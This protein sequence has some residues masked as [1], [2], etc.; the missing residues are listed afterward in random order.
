MSAQSIKIAS[1]NIEDA[2]S[3]ETR[4]D[5]VVKHIIALDADIVML[6]EAF[7]KD[8]HHDNDTIYSAEA[9]LEDA[10]YNVDVTPYFDADERKDTHWFAALTRGSI[11][12]N[13]VRLRLDSRDTLSARLAELPLTITGVH[14]DDRT[15]V[16]RHRQAISLAEQHAS[17]QPN[18]LMGDFNAMHRRDRRARVLHAAGLVANHLPVVDPGEEAP[19][20]PRL[21]RIGSLSSRLVAMAD[22]GTMASLENIYGYKDIDPG[23]HATRGPVQIDHILT[24]FA[25]MGDDTWLQITDYKVHDVPKK[26]SDHRILTARIEY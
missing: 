21:R 26:E 1:W 7:N 19:N 10:G 24:N 20:H 15:E 18:I 12:K 2:L 14:L 4:V 22:G 3:R 16:I 17:D 8:E 6:P 9:K 13:V 5:A 23:L 11:C 25:K